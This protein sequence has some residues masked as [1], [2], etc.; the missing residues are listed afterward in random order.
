MFT[1]LGNIVMK[2]DRD[3]K[4]LRKHWPLIFKRKRE[5]NT[6][7][8]LEPSDLTQDDIHC[9]KVLVSLME[10]AKMYHALSVIG[11]W[12]KSW[13]RKKI[14]WSSLVVETKALYFASAEE[15]DIVWCFL[16]ST[17]L[18][19]NKE[20]NGLKLNVQCQYIQLNMHH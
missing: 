14:H 11:C 10:D 7:G 9:V 1:K 13:R 2:N 6:R 17:K 3:I 4:V 20:N 18:T 15:Q 5:T 16:T 19:L 8:H 12:P